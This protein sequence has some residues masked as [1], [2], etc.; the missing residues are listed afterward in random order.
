MGQPEWAPT[1]SQRPPGG[2]TGEQPRSPWRLFGS[3]SLVRLG[4]GVGASAACLILLASEARIT[5]VQESMRRMDYGLLGV[6]MLLTVAIMVCKAARWRTLYPAEKR[7][8]LRLAIAG[9]AMGQVANWAIPARLGELIRMGLVSMEGEDGD[10][11]QRA[12]LALSAGVLGAEKLCEGMMLL[13]TVGLL[14]LVVGMPLW[15]S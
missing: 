14:L 3:T 11:R 5:A 8:P 2:P 7:P 12:S 1:A 6:A 4:L 9:I 10:P 15:I 13:L